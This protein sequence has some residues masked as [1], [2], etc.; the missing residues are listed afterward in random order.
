[1]CDH[2]YDC[3][4]LSPRPLLAQS[5]RYHVLLK[6][7]DSTSILEQGVEAAF[8]SLQIG[9]SANV[10]LRNEDVGHGG[11]ARHFAEGALNRGS[12]I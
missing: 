1:M 11:L 12:V 5:A 8:L 2:V 9:V 10:L 3:S 7:L 4:V 6:S